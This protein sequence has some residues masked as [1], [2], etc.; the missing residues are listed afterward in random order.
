VFTYD[1]VV[2]LGTVLELPYLT[3]GSAVVVMQYKGNRTN[4][5]APGKV[6]FY[7]RNV[8]RIS[9]S[10]EAAWGEFSFP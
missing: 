7:D 3:V 8:E 4:T 6:V 9:N 10:T 1:V 5:N 2:Y